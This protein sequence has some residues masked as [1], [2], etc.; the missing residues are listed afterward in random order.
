M[1]GVAL[2]VSILD[3]LLLGF[4]FSLPVCDYF[5]PKDEDDR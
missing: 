5:S 2:V 3:G 1:L 4:L